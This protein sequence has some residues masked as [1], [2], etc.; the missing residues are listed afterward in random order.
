[1][2]N[3][4]SRF[5]PSLHRSGFRLPSLAEG[6]TLVTAALALAFGADRAV[7]QRPLGVDVYEGQ[8]QPNWTSVKNSGISYSWAKATEG[9]YYQDPDWSYNQS[10]GRSAGL[11]M[12]SYHF[13]RPDLDSPGSEA[14]Y[15]W[16]FANSKI[17]NDGK[18]VYPAL[19]YETFNG[20][21]G[22]SSY[23]D[24]ANQW[25]NTVFNDAAGNSV[26]IKPVVYVSACNA[27]YLDSSMGNWI[28]WIANYNGENPQSGTPW[29]VCSSDDLWGGWNNWQ[30]TSSGSVGGIG[31]SCDE[32]VFNGNISSFVSQMVISTGGTGGG[33]SSAA[34]VG[35]IAINTDGTL[36]M[37]CVTSNNVPAHEYQNSPNG[38][39]TALFNMSGITGIPAIA[40]ATNT[41]GRLEIFGVNTANHNV[42]HNY[43]TAPHSAWSGWFSL[44]GSG[45][46]NLQA[47]CNADGRLE[48]FGIGSDG[49]ISHLWQTN[50]G[51]AWNTSWADMGGSHIKAGY[52]LAKN[53]DGRLEIFGVSDNNDVW[54]RYQNSAG[55]SWNSWIDLGGNGI[56]P[57]LAFGQDADGRLEIFGVGSGGDIQHNFQ[58]K[59]G[60]GAWNGWGSMGGT[61]CQPGFVCGI[62]PDG[63]LELFC[64][65]TSNND[66]WHKY[67]NVAGGAWTTWYDFGGNNQDPQLMVCNNQNGAMQVFGIGKSSKTIWTNYQTNPGGAWNGWFNMNNAGVKFFFGQ[68]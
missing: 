19:D 55:G 10:S 56:N 40:V 66:V 67:Q 24:W 13:A 49:Y 64:V 16:N 43:Q 28:T 47:V 39:W 27:G 45:I 57:R 59:G 63:R 68:P 11:Y 15:F 8:G 54:H 50:A 38:S 29:S 32:D 3:K 46:T 17:L 58:V 51:G 31:G 20:H 23:S 7:A 33:T 52:V 44:G 22:A 37:F 21:V 25:F 35:P 1:M 9:T 53:S 42:Y 6:T 36:E 65:Q 34:F 41:D 60:G 5:K 30:W 18:T 26:T 2:K 48:V 4:I 61:G 14:S 12:G 62:N